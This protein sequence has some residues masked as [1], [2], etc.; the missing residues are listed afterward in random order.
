M[1]RSLMIPAGCCLLAFAAL[2]ATFHRVAGEG[3]GSEL[4]QFIALGHRIDLGSSP[5][6]RASAPPA[7]FGAGGNPPLSM[8]E[9][10]QV[11]TALAGEYIRPWKQWE[12]SPHRLYSRAAPR[13]IPTITAA[14]EISPGA[15]G[16]SNSF[17]VATITVD[18]ASQPEQTPC[19]IDRGTREALFFAEGQWLTQDE[20][21]KKA[22]RP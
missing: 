8:E 11:L 13:P 4:A 20:W 15:A 16:N 2:L 7:V 12:A 18:K 21:L 17:L 1:N 5:S 6:S 9:A 19:V 14:V 10:E 22:P 3:P